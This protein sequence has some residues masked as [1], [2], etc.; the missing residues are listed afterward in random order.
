MT[1]VLIVLSLLAITA[2]VGLTIFALSYPIR[3][4]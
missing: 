4:R 2:L 1:Y 3:R